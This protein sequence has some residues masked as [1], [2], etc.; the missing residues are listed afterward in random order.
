MLAMFAS[1]AAQEETATIKGIVELGHR[2]PP[3]KKLDVD[4]DPAAAAA[5][6]NGLISEEL[7]VDERGGIKW[8]L[9]FVT[10]G[11]EGQK[12][13]VP[14]STVSLDFKGFQISPRVQGIMAGQAL[15]T[16]NYDSSF[17]VMHL[18]PFHSEESNV[19]FPDFRKP[20]HIRSFTAPEKAIK[21]KCDLHPWE[22]A[23]IHVL[24]HPFFAVTGEDGRF[25]IKGLPPGRY[26]LETWQ[27]K[28]NPRTREVVVQ[29]GETATL[30]FILET[31]D[32][33]PPFP[34]RPLAVSGGAVLVL[35]I[36]LAILLRR[37]K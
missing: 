22:D 32:P 36:A 25:E 11:L 21:A 28:C 15:S 19:G 5:H 24:P 30:N 8:A 34:W 3:R 2:A 29:A 26:T 20:P 23:W 7:A 1:F 33:P 18:M 17:H 27:Q 6:P 9:I 13:S 31:F 10:R 35:G 16:R 12:F 14:T 37:P 4:A